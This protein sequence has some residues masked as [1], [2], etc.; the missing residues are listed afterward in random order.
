MHHF[1]NYL[2][3]FY[4]LMVLLGAFCVRKA[5]KYKIFTY[6]Y[7]TASAFF[8]FYFLYFWN[9]SFA[10]VWD[11]HRQFS[12]GL[13]LSW[14]LF[15]TLISIFFLGETLVRLFCAPFRTKKEK[16][17]PS[18]R[19]FV[20]L[21]G[22]GVAAIPFA[23]MIYGMLWGRYNYRVVKHTLYFD[24][25]PEAFDGYRV[26]HISDIH[27]GSF[28]NAEKVQYGIDMINAQQGDVI[29][30][31]GDLVNNKAEEMRPWIAHFKQL[32]AKDGVYSVL[33]NHDYGDYV[34]WDSPDEK[35]KNLEALKQIHQQLGFCLLNNESV[36]LS[37]G[38]QRI[39][40]VGVE[41]WGQ[42]F[43]KKGNLK[44]ALSQVD[45]KDFKILLSHDPTHWQYE[46]LKDP[47]FIHLTLSGHTHGMQF[48]IEIPGVIKWSPAGWRYKYWGGVYKEKDRYI[49]VNRGFGY[50]A[51]PGR[52][53]M[54]PEITVIELKKKTKEALTS[55]G[56]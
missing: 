24:D 51:F 44:Q 34:Q 38:Q 21:I 39:A 37:R 18:R 53:G 9:E 47:N 55:E 3:I 40:V 16:V 12:F 45:K 26:V 8:F 23:G 13:F 14:L 17:I 20:S 42:G 52:V 7:Y 22:M 35:A 56:K 4:V 29:F 19:R 41:N 31:T 49:N 2:C 25:L 30:F 28:D 1:I 6:L 46:V 5:V 10:G 27:S 32:H 43:V 48:G 50:L 15:V 36:F 33:G 11:Q 54:P